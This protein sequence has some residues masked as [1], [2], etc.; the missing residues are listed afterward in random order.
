MR[1]VLWPLAVVAF[2]VW[3]FAAWVLYSLSDWAAGILASLMGGVLS[4][5]LGPWAQWVSSSLGDVLQ[6]LIV[7]TWAVLG[8]AILTAPAWTRRLVRR[9]S[10][11]AYVPGTDPR[12]GRWRE[13]EAWKDGG[14][15]REDMERREGRSDREDWDDR[16]DRRDR[17]GYV[18]PEFDRLRHL[19]H[20]MGRKYGLKK[21]K[22]KWD[23]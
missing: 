4:A 3:S 9:S 17:R 19:A 20:D 23:D 22:K 2:L 21:W 5:E 16:D 7:V 15:W 8:M 1:L 14:R 10:S 11:A 18:R 6:V 12:A 13:R